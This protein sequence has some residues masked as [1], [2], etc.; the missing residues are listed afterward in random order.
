MI[1]A[2]AIQSL[3]LMALAVAA[4]LHLASQ[5]HGSYGHAIT[6]LVAGCEFSKP[7]AFTAGPYPRSILVCLDHDR[8]PVRA[9]MTHM[10]AHSAGMHASFAGEFGSDVRIAYLPEDG[11]FLI[12][13][14]IAPP[15]PNAPMIECADVIGETRIATRRPRRVEIS[16]TTEQFTPAT[17]E[18]AGRDSCVLQAII[19]V[20]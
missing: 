3:A 9:L 8:D 4:S 20:F 6:E 11:T 5:R 17:R 1:V 19:D 14:V 12:N 15:A 2:Q 16:F 10:K 13:P 7:R 18:F